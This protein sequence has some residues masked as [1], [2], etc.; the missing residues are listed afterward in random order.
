M[1][2][3]VAV[4]QLIGHAWAE[5]TS[6][7]LPNL[8]GQTALLNLINA[9]SN[10]TFTLSQISLDVPAVAT[11]SPYGNTSVVVSALGPSNL[12]GAVTVFYNRQP[13]SRA[14]GG[15]GWP[16]SAISSATTISAL[17]PQ[18]NTFFGTTLVAA[19]IVDGAVAAGASSVIITIASGSY[20]F[21][22]GSTMTLAGAVNT[23]L[24]MPFDGANGSTTIKDIAQ[25]NTGSVLNSAVISTAQSKFGGSS[26]SFQAL[27]TSALS[28]PDNTALHL[29]GDFTIEMFVYL[30]NVTQD[31]V[32]LEK[33][34]GT[35]AT[36]RFWFELLRNQLYLKLLGAS[37]AV[38]LTVAGT[39]TANNW[40]HIA[41]VKHSNVWTG[42]VNGVA[43]STPVA[44]SADMSTITGPLVIG[45][46]SGNS[47]GNNNAAVPGFVDEL[48]ISKIARYTANF[49]PPPA[50]FGID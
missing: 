21:I 1:T 7:P 48:R 44:S 11:A 13:I 25:I 3:S 9:N 23:V 35:S 49:T 43:G 31:C 14:L 29:S 5:D 27:A 12:S 8:A 50:P 24:L 2:A 15:G 40:M 4:R 33:S 28:I 46:E 26:I 36:S 10:R 34:N 38:P 22:P 16:F 18:I 17:L 47:N 6:K 37:A 19:D 30:T 42:Y 32:L 41:V 39:L 45:N 20:M